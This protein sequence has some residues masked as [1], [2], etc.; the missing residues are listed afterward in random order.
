LY[1]ARELTGGANGSG[2]G[3]KDVVALYGGRTELDLPLANQFAEI[4][5]LHE[6]TEDGSRGTQGMVTV[7]LE[8]TLH[9]LGKQATVYCCG[10]WAM[11][12][13]VAQ[14]A[15][16]HGVECQVS[17]ESLMGCGY[18][19]CLGCPTGRADGGYLYTCNDGPCVDAREVDWNGAGCGPGAGGTTI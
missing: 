10:P 12:A 17:L 19:V 18:G 2:D 9:R 4:A 16:S 5:E 14:M 11:M 15:S 1:F 6:C 3:R 7:A 8:T 13:A